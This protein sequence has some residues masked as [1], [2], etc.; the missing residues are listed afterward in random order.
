M[1][2]DEFFYWGQRMIL[3]FSYIKQPF[4]TGDLKTDVMNLLNVNDKNKTAAHCIDV[5]EIF[6]KLFTFKIVH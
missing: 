3:D 5:A 4:M 1:S 2:T 6:L